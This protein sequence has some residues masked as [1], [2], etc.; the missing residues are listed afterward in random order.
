MK[1]LPLTMLTILA[2]SLLLFSTMNAYALNCES[3]QTGFRDVSSTWTGC[4]GGVPG[5]NDIVTIKNGHT[6]IIRTDIFTVPLTGITL[7]VEPSAEL[8]L[9]GRSGGKLQISGG[10]FTNFGKTTL[11]GGTG[12][13]SFANLQLTSSSGTNECSGTIDVNGGSTSAVI[14]GRFVVSNSLFVNK[15]TINLNGGGGAQGGSFVIPNV[16]NSQ[17]DNHGTINEMPGAGANS[18]IVV[19]I[20]TLGIFN[21]NLANLCL[22]VAGSLIPIDTTM[23]LLG[24]TQTTASWLIPVIVAGIGIGI[25]IL[26]KY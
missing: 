22:L 11:A 4:S 1:L 13:Q 25:V 14:V 21:D 7:T 16:L 9:D 5:D 8:G 20:P 2:S 12:A 19:V 3:T 23:V 15:G 18:G 6:V 10:T 26:R 24:A 17:L